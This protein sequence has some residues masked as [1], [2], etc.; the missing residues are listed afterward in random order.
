MCGG[1]ADGTSFS[2][3]EFAR[4]LIAC[5]SELAAKQEALRSAI[6]GALR[7]SYDLEQGTLQI[8]PATF[9]MT[10]V[11]SYSETRKT[12]LWGWA[13]EGL[14]EPAREASRALRGLYDL[15]GFAVFTDDGIEASSEDAQDLSAMAVHHLGAVALFRVPPEASDESSLY[16]ALHSAAPS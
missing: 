11:G 12:W 1:H 6:D 2:D 9:P 4:F 10:V 5:R 15:T 3:E 14:P 13:N 8:G 7:W 16:L